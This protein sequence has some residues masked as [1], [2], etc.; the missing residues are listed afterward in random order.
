MVLDDWMDKLFDEYCNNEEEINDLLDI[1]K[2]CKLKHK[3]KENCKIKLNDKIECY[4]TRED[5]FKMLYKEFNKNLCSIDAGDIC[6]GT[7]K[8]N[9]GSIKSNFEYVP[10]YQSAY[11]TYNTSQFASNHVINEP[12]ISNN[13]WII[14]E[15]DGD[16]II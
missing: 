13:G 14:D 12:R 15:I 1:C 3:T 10:F 9:I 7:I 2:D 8:S 16:R 5:E 6:T 4:K 11:T